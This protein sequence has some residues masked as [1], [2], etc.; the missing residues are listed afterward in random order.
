MLLLRRRILLPPRLADAL[1][2]VTQASRVLVSERR[3]F[4]V[5][6]VEVLDK[7]L[8]SAC[9][10]DDAVPRVD[11]HEE[12]HN[13]VLQVAMH[14]IHNDALAEIE[15]LY[16]RERGVNYRLVLQ[17]V[18]LDTL[19]KVCDRVLERPVAVVGAA[20]P[21]VA[22]MVLHHALVVADAF[23]LATAAHR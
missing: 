3:E 5:G 6:L 19:H 10:V 17:L 23:S 12:E 9:K 20:L 2:K 13:A 1:D 14:I 21:D 16:V 18:L 4:R 11:V 8:A 7:R 22:H 15:D